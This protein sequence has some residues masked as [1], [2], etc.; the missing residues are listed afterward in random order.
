VD[1]ELGDT[2]AHRF[3]VA[4]KRSFKPLDP[5][6]QTTTHRG[7]CQMVKPRGELRECFDA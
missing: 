2:V 3:T 5:G 7:V 6:N 1:S 4:K